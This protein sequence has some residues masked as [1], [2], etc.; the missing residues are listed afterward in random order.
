[1]IL[2]LD[3]QKPGATL[4][5]QTRTRSSRTPTYTPPV[6]QDERH[7]YCAYEDDLC[8]Y[9]LA[10][11]K[12]VWKAQG[13]SAGHGFAMFQLTPNG[14]SVFIF[15]DE[16]KLILARLTPEG[17]KEVGRAF[18]VEATK[19]T[20]VPIGNQPR[21]WAH[22]AY[23]NRHVFARNDKEVVC[24]S[25]AAEQQA[26]PREIEKPNLIQARERAG[27]QGKV[28]VSC[29]AFSP[30]G[31][32]LATGETLGRVTLRDPSTGKAS[33]AIEGQ[34]NGMK[35]VAISPDG[36]L[37]ASAG[38]N[39]SNKSS[40]VKLWDLAAAKERAACKGHTDVVLAVTFAPDGRLL[41]TAGN[42]GTVKLWDVTDGKALA[43]LKDH[44][45]AVSSVA[46]SPDGKTLA[47]GSWDHTVKL[48]D[49]A[50]RRVRATLRKHEDEV[51]AVAFS[52]DGKRLATGGG[53]NR[54]HLWDSGTGKEQAALRGHR[55][56]VHAL[57]FSPDGKFLAT[58]GG[59]E[60]VKLWE[61]ATGQPQASLR[62]FTH[63]IEALAFSPDG[64][65]LVTASKDRSREPVK[66]WDL[67]EH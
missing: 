54:V 61:A 47:S 25:L 34:A 5:R 33:V 13:V 24:V 23:A 46:F 62:G 22:P 50:T 44:G 65:G 36:K 49:V 2:K 55:G 48:W 59:D 35:A 42:D 16:G 64:K 8:C 20:W 18:L 41:A 37:L 51:L 32:V 31:K 19:G 53:D 63:V 9:E 26:D 57:A 56:T 52:P 66:L 4:L 28:K 12:E 15:N 11:G 14:R 38:G 3:P 10:T 27:F 67:L 21:T 40:E 30:D 45:D 58:S 1:M 6:F 17:Y 29:L 7:Y 60:T 43:T 39:K